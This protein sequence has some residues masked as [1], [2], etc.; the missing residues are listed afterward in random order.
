[1]KDKDMFLGIA[2]KKDG[3]IT[4]IPVPYEGA[5]SAQHGTAD[6][7]EAIIK[8][9]HN[10]ELYDEE[11]GRDISKAG[12]MTLHEI[13]PEP[14]PEE[15]VDEIEAAVA[16]ELLKDR[17]PVILGGCHTVTLGAVKALHKRFNN[18]SVLSLD[19]HADLKDKYDGT[20]LS[21]A[22]VMARVNELCSSVTAGV[23]S[24]DENEA[25]IIKNND[26][27]VFFA[28]EIVNKE[29]WHDKAISTLTDNVYITIDLDAFDPSIMASTG[30]PEPG[31]MLWYETLVFLKKVCEK[32]KIVGFDVVELSPR[33]NEFSCDFLAA[34]LV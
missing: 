19:A 14:T 24:I 31:G 17:F 25:L 2:A 20:K 21:H 6:G 33:K 11:L 30:T 28:R 3:R 34:K 23:R 4:I 32:K 13:E 5:C 10:L 15:M 7:P 9:S 29:D 18:L 22:C 26:N 1:M 8:A 12:I 16:K 27:P